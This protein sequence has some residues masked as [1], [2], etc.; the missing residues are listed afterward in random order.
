MQIVIRLD[1]TAHCLY[2]ES[3][4]LRQ[5]GT[6]A[7]ER[8]SYVEPDVDGNWRADLAPQQG[9]LLGPYPSRA[10]AL[11][12]EEAWLLSNWLAAPR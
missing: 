9:P 2:G 6:L 4:D 8:A 7:I 12:A 10:Q 3:I 11:A 1:G 5:L